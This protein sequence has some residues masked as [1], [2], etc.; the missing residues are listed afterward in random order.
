MPGKPSTA[1]SP[2][3][4]VVDSNPRELA[5]IEEELRRRYAED[6]QIVGKRSTTSAL[7]TLKQMSESG[8]TVAVI[9]AE[10]WMEDLPGADFLG[11][12]RRHHPDAKRALLVQWRAWADPATAKAILQA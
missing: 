11:L 6:Y 5:W 12:V 9:L 3:I 4:M 1:P 2:A 10:H 7:M 8:E